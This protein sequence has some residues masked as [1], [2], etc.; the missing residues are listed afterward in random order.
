MAVLCSLLLSQ[1]LFPCVAFSYVSHWSLSER[2]HQY[3]Q[4]WPGLQSCQNQL[5]AWGC[6]YF[7]SYTSWLAGQLSEQLTVNAL[8]LSQEFSYLTPPSA[9]SA[10]TIHTRSISC[11]IFHLLSLSLKKKQQKSNLIF[12]PF[13]SHFRLWID[14]AS[15]IEILMNAAEGLELW[16]SGKMI[17]QSW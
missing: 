16:C 13:F 15:L 5:V 10:E 9:I 14:S 6:S 12:K 7:L 17:N 1:F 11:W 4:W 3:P 8:G 2:L